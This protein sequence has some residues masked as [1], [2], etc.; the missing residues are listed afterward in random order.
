MSMVSPVILS[1]GKFVYPIKSKQNQWFYEGQR[2]DLSFAECDP[3]AEFKA[4]QEIAFKFVALFAAVF[5]IKFVVK[6]IYAAF[7]LET[8]VADKED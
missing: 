7:W 2:I 4:G 3:L 5:V 6:F 8:D 1:D